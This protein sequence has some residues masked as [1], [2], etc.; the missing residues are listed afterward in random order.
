MAIARI[1]FKSNTGAAVTSLVIT[2]D[3]APTNGRLQVMTIAVGSEKSDQIT[4]ITQTN[5]TWVRAVASNNTLG[6]IITAEI[7]YAENTTSPGTTIT[8]NLDD[9]LDIA[10]TYLEYSGVA[11]SSSLD[12]TATNEDFV[13]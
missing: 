12:Q 10:A 2:P 11:T 13:S 7:W 5:A 4:S 6:G 3:V 9:T 1:Q 8:I